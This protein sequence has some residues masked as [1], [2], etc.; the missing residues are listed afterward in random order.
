MKRT[1]FSFYRITTNV[2]N[3]T[4]FELH[5]FQSERLSADS[6]QGGVNTG[7][8]KIVQNLVVCVSLNGF[9]F[10]ARAGGVVVPFTVKTFQ[11]VGEFIVAAH[12][13]PTDKW[14]D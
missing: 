5:D 4:V 12:E 11:F 3:S 10:G 7:T 9:Q 13:T 8:N 6:M 14:R 2:D 1:P